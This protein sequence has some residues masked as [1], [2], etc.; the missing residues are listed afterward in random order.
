LA[1]HRTVEDELAGN[2][3]AELVGLRKGR[4]L[5]AG[6]ALEDRPSELGATLERRPVKPG[7]A[8]EDRPA[9]P[10]IAPEGCPAKRGPPRK[11]APPNPASR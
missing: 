3:R 4:L 1:E 8:L 5:E 6:L 2:Q 11:V 10:G 9:E 7:L